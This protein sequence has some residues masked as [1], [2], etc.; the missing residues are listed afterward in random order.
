VD[1]LMAAR[2]PVLA[3]GSR[4]AEISVTMEICSQDSS[5]AARVALKRLGE[6][7]N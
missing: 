6:S 3:T 5:D 2:I 4:H 7:L 1:F